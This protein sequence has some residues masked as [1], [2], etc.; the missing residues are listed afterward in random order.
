MW[1]VIEII[2]ALA[3]GVYC[4]DIGYSNGKWDE[5]QKGHRADEEKDYITPMC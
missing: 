1:L 2:I 3:V 4:Y 5:N